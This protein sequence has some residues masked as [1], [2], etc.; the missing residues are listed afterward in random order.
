MYSGRNTLTNLTK[1]YNFITVLKVLFK[2]I[3]LDLRRVFIRILEKG[4]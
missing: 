2:E 1:F 3:T 4:P